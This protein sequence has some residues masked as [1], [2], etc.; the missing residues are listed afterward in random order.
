MGYADLIQWMFNLERFGIKLGLENMTEYMSEVGDPHKDF[1]S[2]HVT[3][4]NGKGSVC[5]FLAS[6]LKESGLKVGLYTS[7]HLVD[8]RERITVNGHMIPEEDVVRLGGSLRAT[9]EGMAREADEKQL[10]FFEFTTGLAFKYFGEQEVD[11]AVVEVG[12]GGRLDATNVITPEVSVIT[13]IGLEHT[14]YLGG[15]IEQIAREKA[16][17]VKGGI[18]VV[19]SDLNPTSL[20][21]IQGTCERKG[22]PLR[23]IDEDFRVA[24][25]A[26][27][28]E[29]TSFDYKGRGDLAGLRTRL[30][31][32]H[33]AENAT[34]A[35]A[36][37]E[38][39]M[40]RGY[41]IPENAIRE[42]VSGT[43]WPGRLDIWSRDPLIILDGS[44]NP[45]GVNTSVSVLSALGLTPLTFVVACMSDKDAGGM[46]AAL[47]PHACRI[48]ITEVD[49]GRSTKARDLSVIAEQSFKGELASEEN[50]S[51]AMTTA[52]SDRGTGVCAI[53]SFYLVGEVMRWLECS[54]IRR[55][56]S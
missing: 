55:G 12:M 34:T 56:S 38:E 16:G 1:R 41:S 51:R 4:T 26:T 36:A 2:V 21:V 44:H 35:I 11:I 7:P 8:F 19:C 28:M 30:V 10:T 25:V 27:G 9:M 15:S 49:I 45:E 5:A 54:D 23:L 37:A 40:A 22:S 14:A 47:A 42:G 18:P 53:G 52:L 46:I 6:I 20:R 50:V 48:V 17:I 13:R 3:G 31:G 33:Q 29:G 43:T 39:L 32:V 24:N